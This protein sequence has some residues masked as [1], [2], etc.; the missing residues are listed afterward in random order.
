V[1]RKSTPRFTKS[2]SLVLIRLVL[3]EIQLFKN[4]KINKE[5][6]GHPDHRVECHCLSRHVLTVLRLLTRGIIICMSRLVG[7]DWSTDLALGI[8]ESLRRFE[9]LSIKRLN[10]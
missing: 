6:L 10:A 7:C 2:P 9:L 3:T 1:V 8:L 4:I 5:M